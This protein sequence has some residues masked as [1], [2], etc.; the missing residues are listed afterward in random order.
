MGALSERV[1]AGIG[2]ARTVHAELFAG[3]MEKS[4]FETVLDGDAAR[5][6]L[7]TGE[8]GAVVGND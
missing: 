8:A 1:D 7:P 5:L 3:H 4:C 2:S 6:A